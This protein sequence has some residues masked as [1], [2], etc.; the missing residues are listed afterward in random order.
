MKRM[1]VVRYQDESGA[2]DPLDHYKTKV[3]DRMQSEDNLKLMHYILGIGSEAGELQDALKKT[4]I[5]GKELDVVNIKEELGDLMWYMARTLEVIG[6]SFE[7]ITYI[8]N[9]KLRSR[10]G[11]KFTEHAALNRN[12]DTERKILEQDEE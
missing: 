3:R 1:G 11:E 5:Y 12:L 9:Q 6:C 2:T 10:Y 7:E 8:N 4:L